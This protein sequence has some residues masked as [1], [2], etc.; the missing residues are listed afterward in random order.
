MSDS[1]DSDDSELPFDVEIEKYE[2]RLQL[3]RYKKKYRNDGRSVGAR[4]QADP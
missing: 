4:T 3:A 2:K 1:D